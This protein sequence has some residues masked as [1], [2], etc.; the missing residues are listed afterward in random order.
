MGEVVVE[1]EVLEMDFVVIAEVEGSLVREEEG[2]SLVSLLE[3]DLERKVR[4]SR[5]LRLGFVG[6]ESMLMFRGG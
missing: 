3:W 2:G 4:P 5:V 6:G 1:V